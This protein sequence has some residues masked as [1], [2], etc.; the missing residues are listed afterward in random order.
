MGTHYK[1]NKNEERV[2]N[3][4]I[5]LQ[6]ASESLNTMLA[7]QLAEFDLT[8]S[9]FGV[10]ELLHHKGP[11]NQKSIAQKLLK[12][13]GNIT[14]VIEN[15]SK[16]NYVERRRCTEDRRNIYIDL[17]NEGRTLIE[18]VFPKHLAKVMSAFEDVSEGALQTLDDECKKIGLK[19][20]GLSES[21][22]DKS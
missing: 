17:S 9:Q 19:A 10:L 21:A 6:R 3:T 18:D 8:I 7:R 16:R 20:R 12:T 15:L 13:G 22:S 5:K 4:Y 11:H 1:G 14:L 2:L